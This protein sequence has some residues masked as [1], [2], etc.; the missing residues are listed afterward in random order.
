MLIK[1]V[2]NFAKSGAK[3]VTICG[4]CKFCGIIFRLFCVD[5]ALNG[6]LKRVLW[7]E[8]YDGI[9]LARGGAND[10]E[11]YSL[12]AKSLRE[13]AVFIDVNAVEVDLSAVLLCQFIENG[14]ELSARSAPSGV[15]VHHCRPFA[16][17]FPVVGIDVGDELA[18]LLLVDFNDLTG[19]GIDRLF[20]RVS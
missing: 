19:V 8:T 10:E 15:E 11:R 3:L 7:L 4:L 17:E 2:A 6:L 13:F 1:I 16:Q 12:N 5:N 20:S 14:S 9:W 18:E